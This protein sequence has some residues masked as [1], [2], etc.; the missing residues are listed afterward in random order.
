MPG[1]FTLLAVSR[2]DKRGFVKSGFH[3]SLSKFYSEMRIIV[4]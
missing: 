3:N 4:T 1:I 2:R